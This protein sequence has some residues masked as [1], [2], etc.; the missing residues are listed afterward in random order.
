MIVGSPTIL[1]L[2]PGG[3]MKCVHVNQVNKNIEIQFKVMNGAAPYN[4]PE[5]VTCTIRGTKGDA[6]GYAAEA[7]VTAGS[8]VITVTL[9]EQLTA[10][11]GAGNIFEL[12]F[13]GAADDMKV[14]TENFILAVERQAMG[15]DTVIS[16]SDLSYAEQVLDQLQSVGAV[17]A[18]VQ[19]NKANIAAEITRATA[20]EQTLQQN[21][22][23]EAA[24]RQAADNTLQSNIN[25]EAS[26]RAT[27]DASLQS[28][29]N[30]LVA[31]EGAAPSAAEITNAR[32]GADGTVYQTLGDAIRGQ[33]T[34]VKSAMTNFFT[35]VEATFPSDFKVGTYTP[36]ESGNL[37]YV[38]YPNSICSL[39]S[40]VTTEITKIVAKTGYQF[41]VITKQADETWALGTWAT[42]YTVPKATEIYIVIRKA[43][44]TA[45]KL[46]YKHN[47]TVTL[48]AIQN[49]LNSV[50]TVPV[51]IEAANYQTLLPD[52]DDANGNNVF[53]LNFALNST[54]IPANLPYTSNLNSKTALLLTTDVRYSSSANIGA[55]QMLF[56]QY[57]EI[58][59]RIRL[60]NGWQPWTCIKG[61]TL[62]V[63]V[64]FGRI[65]DAVNVSNA[66]P[67]STIYINAGYYD[68]LTELTAVYPDFFTAYSANRKHGRGLEVGNNVKIVA[69]PDAVILCNY[70]GDDENFIQ[71][72]SPFM[73]LETD[74]E[75]DGVRINCSRIKYGV[76]DD[77][78]VKTTRYRHAYKNCKIIVNNSD[79]P[80]NF[81]A[82]IGGGLGKQATITVEGCYF[83]SAGLADNQGIIGWHNSI[84]NDAE[85]KI[86]I[87]GNYCEQGTYRAGYYGPSTR[88][89]INIVCNNSFKSAPF[90]EREN[91][92]YN[93][94]NMRL[95][96]WNNE[97]RT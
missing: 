64:D 77:P 14:S 57:G 3:V 30:Q 83:S 48:P 56:G 96:A 78:L 49:T 7:A 67:N 80:K 53:I 87:S 8:N 35:N 69:S 16:D 20:A 26:S 46:E 92:D 97:V 6:F 44:I 95:L 81:R 70:T 60:V 2:V 21:I 37:Q 75:M 29:I 38:P 47:V 15:E 19:Q 68:L 76:H 43:D 59:R 79:S 17:N 52:V 63:G 85:S 32:V 39:G 89:T 5:G 84:Q 11:A 4:V 27:T 66:I 45:G 12:V 25:A 34:D 82:C 28:Q 61:A 42:S 65:T 9:T 90:V 1:N 88:P 51:L 58:W 10:V 41:L 36:D 40:Y 55:W 62:V 94:Q 71:N 18:Q 72:F 24:A 31:P 13:V 93:N 50:K 23:A 54:E 74:M 33:V 22:N 86:Y 91:A 73:T